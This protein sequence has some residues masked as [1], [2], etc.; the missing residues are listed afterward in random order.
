MER[1]SGLDAARSGLERTTHVDAAGAAGP[2]RTSG[3]GA[4][5]LAAAARRPSG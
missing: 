3:A 4:A 1:T 5:Q 2:G